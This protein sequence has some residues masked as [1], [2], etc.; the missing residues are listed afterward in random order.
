VSAR[1][2]P[3]DPEPEPEPSAHAVARVVPRGARASLAGEAEPTSTRAVVAFF[4]R[5]SRVIRRLA[6]GEP[7]P[8]AEELQAIADRLREEN[9]RRQDGAPVNVRVVARRGVRRGAP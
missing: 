4:W 5:G 9:P 7:D 2:F 3:W 1:R 8:S 6:E